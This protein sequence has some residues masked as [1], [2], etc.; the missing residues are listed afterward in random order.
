MPFNQTI[1]TFYS[2]FD[3]SIDVVF[4]SELMVVTQYGLA[5]GKFAG[6]SDDDQSTKCTACIVGIP[7]PSYYTSQELFF[8]EK[9]KV[10]NKLSS[11]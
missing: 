4:N 11:L 6:Y 9:D 2:A 1:Y 3:S 8:A 5:I 7:H 10:K